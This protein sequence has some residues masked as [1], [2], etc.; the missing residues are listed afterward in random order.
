MDE[1]LEE[2]KQTYGI[3][4][5]RPDMFQFF[6][7]IWAAPE[8]YGFTDLNGSAQSS[9]GDDD[10]FFFWDGAHFTQSAHLVIG[11]EIYRQLMVEAEGMS[12]L[13][14]EGVLAA[15]TAG[16]ISQLPTWASSKSTPRFLARALARW[17][18]P[19]TE[20]CR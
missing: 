10:E 6:I 15:A 12:L 18:S 1:K 4:V 2:L 14:T 5:Y 16:R 8:A 9:P 11:Q 7:D 3:T 19:V 20:K 13:Q 17:A